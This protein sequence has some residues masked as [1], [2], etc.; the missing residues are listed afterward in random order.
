MHPLT[1]SYKL[2]KAALRYY[3]LILIAWE[4][5]A[6]TVRVIL[7]T[8]SLHGSFEE[9]CSIFDVQAQ[10]GYMIQ[11]SRTPHHAPKPYKIHIDCRRIRIY[12]T[13]NISQ[14]HGR[15]PSVLERAYSGA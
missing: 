8:P 4:L 15:S 7:R 9:F 2:S 14:R 5:R 13:T 10:P 12:P 3:T 11:G 6:W 1:T